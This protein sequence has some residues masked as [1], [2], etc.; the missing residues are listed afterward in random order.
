MNQK[1]T[2]LRGFSL[3][4]LILGATITGLILLASLSFFS[5]LARDVNRPVI[6][7]GGNNYALAPVLRDTQDGVAKTD[8]N[9]AIDLHLELNRQI[10]AA[11]LVTVFGGSNVNAS[12]PA[13]P[14]PIATSF[15]LQSLSTG[16]ST[17]IRTTTQLLSAE[18]ASIGANLE[19]SADGANFTL[20]SIQGT[21]DIVAIAQVRR[22]TTTFEGKSVVLYATTLRSRT[23]P[24]TTWVN[25]AYYFWLPADEDV[26]AVNIGAQHYWYRNDTSWWTRAESAGSTLVFPDPYALSVNATDL[27][28]KPMS[29]FTYFINTSPL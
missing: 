1:I 18:S 28:V 27:K 6:I 11:D 25:F 10:T 21:T 12:I 15:A 8:L 29:R 5:T 24:S 19:T 20:L 4:E 17:S 23:L 7:Y 14:L 3:I 26:W 9:D 22:Y 16:A 13:A 2:T